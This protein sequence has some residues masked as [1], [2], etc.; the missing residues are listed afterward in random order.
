ME[1]SRMKCKCCDTHIPD[2]YVKGSHWFCSDACL[3]KYTKLRQIDCISTD[4]EIVVH[5][6]YKGKDKVKHRHDCFTATWEM[7]VDFKGPTEAFDKIEEFIHQ[8]YFESV[9]VP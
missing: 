9:I 4:H 1:R 8:L 2:E 6:K 3:D 5:G 7:V